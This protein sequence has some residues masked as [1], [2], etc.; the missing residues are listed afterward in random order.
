MRHILLACAI[1]SFAE[2][3]GAPASAE[4]IF[5][6]CADDTGSIIH[7]IDTEKKTIDNRP[8]RINATSI[9]WNTE[10]QTAKSSWHIDRVTGQ[11][12]QHVVSKGGSGE[13]TFQINCSVTTAPAT[14]F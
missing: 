2:L 13:A 7:T 9:D 1:A 8:A 11:Q 4:I 10:G 12:T 3:S 5:L 14:K 6:R